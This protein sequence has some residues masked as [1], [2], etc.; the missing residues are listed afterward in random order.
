MQCAE[1]VK[2]RPLQLQAVVAT[3]A[4]TYSVTES[5]CRPWRKDTGVK[6]LAQSLC[7]YSTAGVHQLLPKRHAGALPLH[8]NEAEVC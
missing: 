6:T 4:H 7:G 5:A 8:A 2:A 1:T 3:S